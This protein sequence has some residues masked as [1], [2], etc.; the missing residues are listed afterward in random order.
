MVEPLALWVSPVG[1]LGG[2][3]RHLLDVARVGIPGW[4][5]V[6][7]TP[8][9][10]LAE[11][12]RAE[13]AAVIE[14]PFGP[15]AGLGTSIGTLRAT[16]RR[17]H[18]Q[19][20]HTHLS[21]ADIVA[22]VG[23]VG[24]RVRLATTEHGIA[25]DDL[26]YHSSPV[27]ASVMATVHTV[28]L[29]AFSVVVAV[30][31]ATRR[32]MVA[33]WHPRRAIQLIVNGVDR[34]TDTPVKEPGLRVLS[35]ARLAPEKRI[36]KLLEAFALLAMDHP[37]A[38]LRI[39]G[40]GPLDEDLRAQTRTLGIADR[41]AFDGFVPASDAMATA[42]VLVQLS[43]W[44]NCSYSLLDAMTHGLGVCA[45]PVGGNPELLPTRC[46]AQADDPATVAAV[47]VDQGTRLD[48]RPTLPNGWPMVAE[49]TAQLAVAYGAEHS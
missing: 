21:Y 36:D 16:V 45:T 33:K 14:A 37:D 29:R 47:I 41:V 42:D 30:A 8:P 15:D 49:M 5:L 25:A 20:V 2:V 34:P 48:R 39:A 13:G 9:G 6:F 27:E 12:L 23:L 24:M 22:A 38:T 44:E 43:V 31:E 19:V 32:A 26:V 10:T 28:R 11:R 35:L 1:D 46:L 7:L 4:R 3:A 18:P 17:L 40:V